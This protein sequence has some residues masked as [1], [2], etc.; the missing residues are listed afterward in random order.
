[1]QSNSPD[2]APLGDRSVLAL[3]ATCGFA[4]A[5]LYYSQPLLPAIAASFGSGSFAQGAIAMLTQ[6]G[7]ACGLL[8][9][10]PLGD[11]LDRRALIACLLTANIAALVSCALATHL[12]L[13]LAANT[14]LGLTAVSAQ[15][16][17]PAVSGLADPA[18]R[19]QT[20]GR[21][22]GGLFAGTLLAR[23]VSGL[24]GAHFGWRTTFMVAALIELVPIALVW[25]HLP[26]TAANTRLPYPRLLASLGK[27]LRE[28][29]LLRE[30]CLTGFVLYAAFNLLWGSLALLLAR[31]PYHWGSDVA[32]LFGLVGLVGMLASPT[33][34]RLADRWGGRRVVAL[35]AVSI[36]A[37][38]AL[39]AGAGRW[40]GWLAA[41]IVVLDLG[42]R[43]NLVANQTRLYALLPEARGR[44]N[45]VF[46][47]SYFLGGA[48][49]SAIGTAVAARYGWSGLSAAGLLCG[50]LA[51]GVTAR[52]R[53]AGRTQAF[54]LP[55]PGST[56]SA[57]SGK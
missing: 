44:L 39:V 37:A 55:R 53:T 50:A 46:M 11:R 40:V 23:T 9:F 17:I 33:T 30:A 1:M 36:M 52:F 24:L 10:G 8:L 31:A 13:L 57:S 6:F 12:A 14:M 28:Q 19:G 7:Y 48:V 4:V 45:T 47:T 34:G 41:G 21:L 2:H 27:L 43:A 29:P 16:V 3:S 22:M 26:R 38:F 25:R 35:A 54:A 32:G 20:V 56:S 18:R 51:L 42:S 49:G 15:I 5:S